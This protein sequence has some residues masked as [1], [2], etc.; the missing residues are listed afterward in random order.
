MLHLLHDRGKNRGEGRKL[1]K[2]LALTVALLIV[3]FASC[4][5]SGEGKGDVDVDL[6]RMS[7]TMVYAEV[8]NMLQNPDEYV[9]KTVRM[10]GQFFVTETDARNYYQCVVADATACCSNG[11]E[12]VRKGDPAYPDDYPPQDT[13]IVVVGRF[14]TYTEGISTYIQIADAS[15]TY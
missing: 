1:K 11:I 13:E 9:G 6:T 7:S 3:F 15:M 12:F 10:A 4:S 14:E 5:G 8:L 2:A